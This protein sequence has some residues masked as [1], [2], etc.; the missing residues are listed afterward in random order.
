[1]SIPPPPPHPATATPP[2]KPYATFQRV[3]YRII[4]ALAALTG[5]LQ[6]FFYFFPDLPRCNSDAARTTIG[7]IFKDKKV[8]LTALTNLRTLTHN[9]SEKTCQADF[10]TPTE[11]GTLSYRIYWKGKNAQVEITKVEGR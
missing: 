11:A 6:L 5:L 9:T 1:M 4:G 3:A 10:K 8:E 7:D 2:P